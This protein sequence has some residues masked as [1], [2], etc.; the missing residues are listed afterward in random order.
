MTTTLA[1]SGIRVT[2]TRLIA[3]ELGRSN[4]KILNQY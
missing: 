3:E 4:I 2:T 1:I